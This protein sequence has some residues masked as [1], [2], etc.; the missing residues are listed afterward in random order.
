MGMQSMLDTLVLQNDVKSLDGI[1]FTDTS[2]WPIYLQTELEGANVRQDPHGIHR[3]WVDCGR[4]ILLWNMVSA[5]LKLF[6][7]QGKQFP[8]VLS[9]Y[10]W[11]WEWLNSWLRLVQCETSGHHLIMSY[12]F[13]VSTDVLMLLIPLPILY[14]SQLAWKKYVSADG[15]KIWCG[16]LHFAG[17]SYFAAYSAWVYLW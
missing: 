11:W 6:C 15:S 7:C 12:V 4:S 1:A 3:F 13:N 17:R 10:S 2:I 9:W 16:N 14:Q 5:F 8:F